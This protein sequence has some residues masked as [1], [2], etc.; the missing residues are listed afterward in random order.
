MSK[1]AETSIGEIHKE[2]WYVYMSIA[3]LRY[4]ESI[5]MKVGRDFQYFGE[6]EIKIIGGWDEE[7]YMDIA[8]PLIKLVY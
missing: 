2:G 7:W 8:N 5:P 6:R 4:I 1:E 3:S